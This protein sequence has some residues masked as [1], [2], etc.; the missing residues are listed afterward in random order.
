MP[1]VR[2]AA[3]QGS[4]RDRELTPAEVS[5]RVATGGAMSGSLHDKQQTSNTNSGCKVTSEYTNNESTVVVMSLITTKV[6]SGDGHMH[7]PSW[8]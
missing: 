7:T 3:S 6:T 8:G 5:H 4:S 1:S 2:A